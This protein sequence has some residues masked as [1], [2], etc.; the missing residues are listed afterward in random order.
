MEHN[1][2]S[3][4]NT[5]AKTIANNY[6]VSEKIHR[7]AKSNAFISLKGHQLNFS[8]NPK[9]CSINPAKCEIGKVS[10]FF[11]EQRNSKVTDLSSENQWQETS[12]IITRLKT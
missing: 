4:I 9:R 10:K 7:L 11:S 5:E 12:T 3:K 2:C 8:L 6:G 1:I